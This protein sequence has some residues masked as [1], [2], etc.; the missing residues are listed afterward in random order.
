MERE[1]GPLVREA[2]LEEALQAC[3]R[4]KGSTAR[5]VASSVRNLERARE[6][7]GYAAA[8]ATDTLVGSR[9]DE[10]LRLTSSALKRARQVLK[11]VDLRNAEQPGLELDE[12]GPERT[13]TREGG[14]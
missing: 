6:Q 2:R 10:A 9:A 4:L 13:P 11:D 14:S 1:V 12:S 7:L 5:A 8:N 3:T